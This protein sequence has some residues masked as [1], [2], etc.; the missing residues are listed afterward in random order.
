MVVEQPNI[1]C[2]KQTDF[3]AKPATVLLIAQLF[4]VPH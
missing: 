3:I 2:Y 4:I 1:I